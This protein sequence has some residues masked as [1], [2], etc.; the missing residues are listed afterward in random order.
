MLGVT[1]SLFAFAALW[2]VPLMRDCF[3]LTCGQASLY[4][5]VALAGFAVGCFIMGW[6][7][8]HLGR[9]RPGMPGHA[10]A[11]YCPRLNP[12]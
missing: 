12:L 10:P 6:L 8:D 1:G 4:T 2:G 11:A 5:T 3:G 9:R 7:S